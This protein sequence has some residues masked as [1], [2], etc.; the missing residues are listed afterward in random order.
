MGFN[1]DRIQENLCKFKFQFSIYSCIIMHIV[2]ELFKIH[3]QWNLILI[4]VSKE[5]TLAT[6]LYEA[7]EILRISCKFIKLMEFI[8]R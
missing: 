2:I 7:M 5:F 4:M 6:K 3:F 8:S 1:S